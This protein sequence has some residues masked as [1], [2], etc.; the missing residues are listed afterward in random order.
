MTQSKNCPFGVN[1]TIQL[2]N[3]PTSGNNGI[4]QVMF[5][6]TSVPVLSDVVT[7]WRRIVVLNPNGNIWCVPLLHSLSDTFARV[8]HYASPVHTLPTY[9]FGIHFNNLSCLSQGLSSGFFPSVL[10]NE[11]WYGFLISSIPAIYLATD[12]DDED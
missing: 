11:N 12:K 8:R 9:L 5:Q 6:L 3:I 10:E 4:Y 2:Q 7:F 1:T